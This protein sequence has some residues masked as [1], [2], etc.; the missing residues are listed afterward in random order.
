[1]SENQI[2][3]DFMYIEIPENISNLQ[4]PKRYH[5]S[6]NLSIMPK[7]G[8]KFSRFFNL[9]VVL[10]KVCQNKFLRL[11]TMG[12]ASPATLQCCTDNSMLPALSDFAVIG[13]VAYA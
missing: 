8:S 11:P 4:V 12:L 6:Y 5:G 1:M 3:A 9:T 10:K 13:S 7:S 2:S